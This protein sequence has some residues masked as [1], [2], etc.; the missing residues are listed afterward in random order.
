MSKEK[1]DVMVKG[2]EATPAPLIGPALSPLKVN[3][4]EIVA[5]INEKTKTFKGM[6]VPVKIT[7]DMDTK[8]FEISV[9][10]PP[11]ASLLKK[12]MGVQKLAT[13]GEDKIRKPAGNIAFDKIV[14]ITKGKED[15]I[16]G[17]NFKQ[18][19]K[20]VVGT[21]VSAG[22]TVDGKNPKDVMKEIDAG[23]YDSHFK[24]LL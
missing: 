6:E 18:K 13:V 21:C 8:K 4:A 3:V 24:Q 23:K 16:I 15:A 1:V 12:E 10:T 7:V 17:R 5:A 20:Q 2:G 11:V 19:V 14:S 9:G 22:V